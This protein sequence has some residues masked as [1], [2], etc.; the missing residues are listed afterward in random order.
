MSSNQAVFVQSVKK[1]ILA[2]FKTNSLKFSN[3][4]DSIL[5]EQIE[6]MNIPDTRFLQLKSFQRSIVNINSD[7][8]ARFTFQ[9]RGVKYAQYVSE[10]LGTNRKY[11]KR[12]YLKESANALLNYIINGSYNLKFALGSPNKGPRKEE[13]RQF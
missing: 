12:E 3:K 1:D 7:I 5:Q 8:I 10:G 6:E 4:A 9:T 2:K 11:G 13:R